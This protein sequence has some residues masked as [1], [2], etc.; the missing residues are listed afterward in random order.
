VPCVAERHNALP[1]PGGW[2]DP[3]DGATAVWRRPWL[4]AWLAFLPLALLRAGTLAESD[5]FWQ[6]RTGLI[7]L[8]QHA[9]PT[10]DTFS[11]TAHGE[12]WILN[13]WGF[14]VLIAAAY[15][16]AG[17]PGV[18]LTGAAL[19]MSV[20]GLVLLLASQ[21]GASPIVAGALLWLASPLLI[22]WLSARPQLVDYVA[23]LV[24]VVLL[25]RLVDDHHRVWLVLLIGALS[26]LWVN[27]HAGALLG[28]GIITACSALQ[29]LGAGVRGPGKW[30]LVAAAL[31]L[32]GSLLN[33]LGI[34][35]L[36]QT[37]QVKNE[38]SGVIVEWEH[39]DPGNA[40]QLAMLA[41]GLVALLLSVRRNDLIFVG[42]LGFTAVGALIA[43]RFLPL[44]VLQAL[45]VLAAS[46][47]RPAVLRYIQSRRVVL[48]PAAWLAASATMAVALPSLAHIGQPLPA[49]YPVKAVAD[50]PI[51]CNLYNTEPLG[52]LV[53]LQRPDVLVSLDSRNVLYGHKRI[54]AA[55]RT[56]QGRGDV[57]SE[58]AQAGCVLLPPASGL[59]ERLYKDPAWELKTRE[60]SAVLFVRAPTANP[61][62]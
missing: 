44:L 24:L 59:A 61:A 42:T 8:E 25:R 33:P 47:S 5:T 39:L 31:A 52:G 62:R 34:D 26:A 45:P 41:I 40:T 20:G 38:S 35:L 21:L 1:E 19:V 55:A 10:V 2:L 43:I 7:T 9:I 14:N 53:I 12:H 27:F 18:A 16:V 28:V 46:A 58:L 13:S 11:W 54:N 49:I 36:A 17:L 51:G 22:G 15:R 60:K 6:I 4:W 30:C 50:I 57:S 37:V 48:F 29:L 32:V 3:S 56:L 23:V